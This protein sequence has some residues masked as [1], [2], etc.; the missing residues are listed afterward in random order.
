MKIAAYGLVEGFGLYLVQ[1][2]Q[3]CIEHDLLP[4]DEKYST[5]DLNQCGCFGGH[6]GGQRRYSATV[7]Y[8]R[9]KQG[10]GTSRVVLVNC[11]LEGGADEGQPGFTFVLAKAVLSH[12][13]FQ[14]AG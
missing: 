11:Q 2:G 14:S 8:S 5:L 4:A 9:G 1:L 7:E 3:V 13:W 6:V 12:Q 10:L